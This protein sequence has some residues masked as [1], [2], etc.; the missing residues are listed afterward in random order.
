[1]E[2]YKNIWL[3]ILIVVVI[4]LFLFEGIL[5]FL[6]LAYGLGGYMTVFNIDRFLFMLLFAVCIIWAVT[7]LINVSKLCKEKVLD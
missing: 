5:L 2:K 7:T 3:W 1:M 6:F 4:L